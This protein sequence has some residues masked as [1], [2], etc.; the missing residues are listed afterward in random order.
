MNGEQIF[1]WPP[2]TGRALQTPTA[3][4]GRNPLEKAMLIAAE[5]AGTYDAGAESSTEGQGPSQVSSQ[6]PT[7]TAPTGKAQPIKEDD[8][9]ITKIV[10]SAREEDAE[11][12]ARAER[13]ARGEPE[14]VPQL[15]KP[16][17]VKRPDQ[18]APQAPQ[19][20]EEEVNDPLS[21]LQKELEALSGPK[22]EKEEELPEGLDPNSR[23]AETIRRQ[24]ARAQEAEAAL[25]Q[26]QQTSY[27]TNSQLM[28]MR[29]QFM[30]QQ[31]VM[32]E[33]L[34]ATNARYEA[35]LQQQKM[36]E[37][38]DA[39]KRLQNEWLSKVDSLVQERLTPLQKE[40]QALQSRLEDM[41][42]QS[43]L[44]E[45]KQRNA[46]Q[47]QQALKNIVF[48]GMDPETISPL[49]ND[50]RTLLYATSVEKNIPL[51]E[52]AKQFRYLIM[53]GAQAYLKGH[54]ARAK[55]QKDASGRA[56]TPPPKSN[57]RS[58]ASAPRPNRELLRHNG[59]KDAI[60]WELDGRPPLKPLKK[61]PE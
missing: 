31:A 23:A 24:R 25:Q 13:K 48:S 47:A 21:L 29:E 16:G 50:Y 20:P 4:G 22:P 27:Q 39:G 55:Q 52:A 26:M 15:K 5:E 17:F 41:G 14:P 34:A 18:A 6:P 45:I 42:R 40:N 38:Q 57:V 11:R 58:E 9:I 51:E 3:L 53:A 59:Y 56:P 2:S 60:A 36:S 7:A 33:Q 43:Q 54:A 8:D 10:E 32:R 46:I 49:A 1:V 37:E 28:Q 61:R 30:E 19:Q 12:Q 44:R 35:M